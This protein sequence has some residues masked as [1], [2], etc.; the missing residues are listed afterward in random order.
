MLFTSLQTRNPS[1]SV[2]ATQ[3]DYQKFFLCHCFQYT[4][5]SVRDKR[6]SNMLYQFYKLNSTRFAYYQI[7]DEIKQFSGAVDRNFSKNMIDVSIE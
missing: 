1:E 5:S 6:E 4:S 2:Y 7:Q 3:P